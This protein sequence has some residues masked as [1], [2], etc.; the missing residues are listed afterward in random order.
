MLT[1]YCIFQLFSSSFNFKYYLLLIYRYQSPALKILH[2]NFK[3]AN[4]CNYY[5]YSHGHFSLALEHVQLLPF[6]LSFSF[7]LIFLQTLALAFDAYFCSQCHPFFILLIILVTYL[8]L[9][10]R[11]KSTLNLSL[12]FDRP[13]IQRDNHLVWSYYELTNLVQDY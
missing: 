13:S 5:S 12:A 7:S 1:L 10:C 4:H 9:L 6:L 11:F 2:P 8:C 3:W